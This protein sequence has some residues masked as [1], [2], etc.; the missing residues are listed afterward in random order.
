MARR[1]SVEL[2]SAQSFTSFPLLPLEIQDLIWDHAINSVGPRI[3]EIRYAVHKDLPSSHDDG[4]AVFTSSCPIPGVLHAN[5]RS[6]ERAL[7]RWKLSFAR[8]GKPAKIFFDF[9]DDILLFGN[10]FDYIGKLREKDDNSVDRSELRTIAFFT[11]HCQ[12]YRTF[13]CLT[14]SLHRDFPALKKII[15]LCTD[16]D[17]R[18]K[19]EGQGEIQ[20]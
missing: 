12:R 7:Q 15:I 9:S 8:H 11:K 3:V 18:W 20:Q 1:K 4:T 19:E 10:K 16:S 2:A 5:H 6:R 13:P 14:D 17:Y